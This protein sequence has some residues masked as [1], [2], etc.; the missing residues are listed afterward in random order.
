MLADSFQSRDTKNILRYRR[1]GAAL[2]VLVSQ[3]KQIKQNERWADRQPADRQMD[4]AE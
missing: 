4:Y 3:A 1:N 2:T